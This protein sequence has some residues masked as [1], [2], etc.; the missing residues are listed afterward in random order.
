MAS[1]SIA[2]QKHVELMPAPV[3]EASSLMLMS[4]H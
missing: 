1:A 4:I 2:S 3:V